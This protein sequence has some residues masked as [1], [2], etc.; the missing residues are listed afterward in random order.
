MDIVNDT[1]AFR[2]R[3]TIY[4][5][6]EGA[7]IRK[8]KKLK[9]PGECGS[10]NFDYEVKN[11]EIYLKNHL[12]SQYKGYKCDTTCCNIIED[13][14]YNF[15][16]DIDFSV[17]KNNK[18]NLVFTQSLLDRYYVRSIIIGK[19][20]KKYIE[21][22]GDSIRIEISGKFVE[23]EDIDIWLEGVKNSCSKD[24]YSQVKYEIIVD[25][26]VP[27]NYIKAVIDILRKNGPKKIILTCLNENSKGKSLEYVEYANFFDLSTNKKLR[28]I[29]EGATR[30]E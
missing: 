4:G 21:Q 30:N 26:S 22:Y 15:L 12:G 28:E 16:I 27:V 23:L 9:F 13:Y 2:Y 24:E 29:V 18:G 1:L 6:W 20:K 14:T 5:E 19:P 10:G 17:L 11:N 3:N 25:R 7:W 8:E